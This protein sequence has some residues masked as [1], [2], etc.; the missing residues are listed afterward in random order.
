MKLTTFAGTEFFV[1]PNMICYYD[2]TY[3]RKGLKKV[4]CVAVA[5]ANGDNI[6]VQESLDELHRK[7]GYAIER[8]N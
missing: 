4:P 5:F 8:R 2:I 1:N 3:I 7:I 6:A